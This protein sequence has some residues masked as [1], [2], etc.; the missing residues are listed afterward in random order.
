MDGLGFI[1][2]D[3]DGVLVDTEKWYFMANRRA[4]AEL[5]VELDLDEYMAVMQSGKSAFDLALASGI[6]E[7]EVFSARKNRNHYYQEFLARENIVVP[8]VEP[9]LQ[10]LSKDYV[11]G[12][13]TTSKKKD[14]NLIHKNRNI[15]KYMDFVLT[16]EDYNKSKPDPQPYLTALKR[17]KAK[18][19]ECLAIEDSGR[20]LKSA[21]SAGIGC[22]IIESEFTKKH[23][24][25]GAKTI[26]KSISELPGYLRA[27][28]R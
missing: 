7:G 18:K 22:I 21:V 13:V 4:L 10:E 27:E 9:V 8:N 24:F 12:I 2:W 20:G 14:F 19:D 5:S 26:L 25:T 3:N 28:S 23:D 1:L 16:R 11:M 17:L 6:S 15:L